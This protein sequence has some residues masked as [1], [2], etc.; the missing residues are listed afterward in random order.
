LIKGGAAGETIDV[1]WEIVRPENERF[2]RVMVNRVWKRYFGEGFVE[3]V[4]DWE[5]NAPSHPE[6]LDWL[7]REFVASGYDLRHL[8]RLILNTEAF[9]REAR[10][11][12]TATPDERF[13]EAPLRQRFSAEQIVDTLLSAS[14]VPNY[15]E[16]LTFDI[17]GVYPAQNFLNLGFPERAWQMVSTASDRD[18]PSL[19]LPN[20]D[21]IL[22]VMTAN[23]WRDERAEP[24]Y[25]R[26][27][28]PNVIQPGMLANSLMG[29]WVTR[30]SDYSDL[31]GLA[32]RAESAEALVDELFLHYLTRRPTGDEKAAFLALVAPGF[33]ERLATAKPDFRKLPYIPEVREV[34]WTNHLSVEANEISARLE[35]KAHQGPPP[36][37][38]VKADWRER[39]EDAVWALVNSPEMAFVP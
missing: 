38:W 3:P 26:L 14:G 35:A 37:D 15:S 25:E 21:S 27:N 1:A 22:A 13:F 11:H 5:G 18:R 12:R 34:S 23:G 32:I 7:G 28:E 19:T 10:F 4:G 33:E 9:R 2:A 31:T 16:E 30:L 24:I 6:L 20:A 29:V 36:T 17:E 39:M 8:S